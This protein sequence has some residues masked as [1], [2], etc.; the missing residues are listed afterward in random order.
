MARIKGLQTTCNDGMNQGLA[1]QGRHLMAHKGE[2]KAVTGQAHGGIQ[3]RP[4]FSPNQVHQ[5]I[6]WRLDP[7]HGRIRMKGK[8]LTIGILQ[9]QALL[10]HQKH[11]PI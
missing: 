7:Q 3:D 8:G 1:L 6:A 9:D 5:G 4:L 11:I 10:G 2:D